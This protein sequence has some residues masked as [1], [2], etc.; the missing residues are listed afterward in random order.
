MVRF[1]KQRLTHETFP[2]QRTHAPSPPAKPQEEAFLE[3]KEQRNP[4]QKHRALNYTAGPKTRTEAAKHR[5]ARDDGQNRAE[6]L[7]VE[8]CGGQRE[9]LA[10]IRVLLTQAKFMPVNNTQGCRGKQDLIAHTKS[11]QFSSVSSDISHIPAEA[12]LP[13]LPWEA[14]WGGGD[15]QGW[16]W[17]KTSANPPFSAKG[18]KAKPLVRLPV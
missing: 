8:G 10:E 14:G 17:V 12:M 5:E 7:L 4:T 3:I 1:T 18:G 11:S 6:A 2:R 9:A 13:L 15:I 16:R